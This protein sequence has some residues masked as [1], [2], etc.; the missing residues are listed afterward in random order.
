MIRSNVKKIMTER[1]VTYTALEK[2]TGVSSQTI[3]RARTPRIRE[4][5]L[6]K[7]RK[8]AAALGVKIK[9]LFDE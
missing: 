9:D 6:E 3:T 4:L 2:L 1:Q 8:I 5:S 7:L